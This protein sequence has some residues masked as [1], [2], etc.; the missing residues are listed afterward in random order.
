MH[1][2]WSSSTI[3]HIR[4]TTINGRVINALVIVDKATAIMF[5][6][7]LTRKRNKASATDIQSNQ[8]TPGS[9]F[10][11]PSLSTPPH[12][13]YPLLLV[14]TYHLHATYTLTSRI[15]ASRQEESRTQSAGEFLP[16]RMSNHPPL[17]LYQWIWMDY[18]SQRSKW[19]GGSNVWW[20]RGTIDRMLPA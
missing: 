5:I 6:F 2:P 11:Y 19:S 9:T 7:I 4:P 13:T 16:N 1:N 18:R 8:P 14:L 12:P 20:K 15:I 3:D 17:D 10:H